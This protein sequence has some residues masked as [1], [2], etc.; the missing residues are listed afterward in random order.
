MLG[1]VDGPPLA[2]SDFLRNWLEDDLNS[3]FRKVQ[4]RM[5]GDAPGSL[6]ENVSLD[7]IAF[8]LQA[9]EFP[10]GAE[11]LTPVGAVLSAIRIQSKDGPGP[12][13]NFSL[14]RVVGC[15][16]QDEKA[17]WIVTRGTEPVRARD[18]SPSGNASAVLATSLGAQTFRL[19]DA[20]ASRPEN[21]KGEKVEVKG[22]LMRQADV[23]VLNVTSVQT[24]GS[25]CP[26]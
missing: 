20:A 11:E 7:I 13:P 3:L 9:N 1:G 14:V 6:P 26:E 5:P 19:M 18:G 12:V 15:L 23:T 21:H 8:L 16:T 25:A 2:G 22:L 17:Q 4:D 10:S 24:G